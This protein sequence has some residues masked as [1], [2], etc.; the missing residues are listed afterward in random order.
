MYIRVGD[1]PLDEINPD[2]AL[3][4]HEG[5]ANDLEE[6]RSTRRKFCKF[7]KFSHFKF[8]FR[9]FSIVDAK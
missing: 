2:L 4:F 8:D 1:T 7:T 9:I 5:N 3:A 6:V